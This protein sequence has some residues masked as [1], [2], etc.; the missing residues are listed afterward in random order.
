MFSHLGWAFRDPWPGEEK[1]DP[2]APFFREP[3]PPAPTRGLCG[4]HCTKGASFIFDATR[5]ESMES[6]TTAS[7]W[8]A[9]SSNRNEAAFEAYGHIV[10]QSQE[11]QVKDRWEEM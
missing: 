7:R 9:F 1:R 8:K 3:L 11:N 6:A 4:G 2:K 5:Q 10:H